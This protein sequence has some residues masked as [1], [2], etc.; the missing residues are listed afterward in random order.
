MPSVKKQRYISRLTTRVTGKHPFELLDS[1]FFRLRKIGIFICIKEWYICNPSSWCPPPDV[2]GVSSHLMSPRDVSSLAKIDGKDPSVFLSRF[3]NNKDQ[4]VGIFYNETLAGYVWYSQT[5]MRIPELEYEHPL[6]QNEQF[7]YDGVIQPAFRG[8]YLFKP[9][10]N[11]STRIAVMD[12]RTIIGVIDL[13]NYKSRRV[14]TKL[15]Y[16]K[17]GSSVFL[18]FGRLWKHRWDHLQDY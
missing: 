11:H 6:K 16:F 2:P 10:I 1:I 12:K 3:Q 5:Q 4:C 9:L 7:S 18:K 15:G 17:I 8:R 14:H 13:T